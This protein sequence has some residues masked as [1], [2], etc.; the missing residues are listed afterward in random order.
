MV[1]G[2]R[3]GTMDIDPAGMVITTVIFIIIAVFILF[4]RRD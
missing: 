2:N 3:K 4:A 1:Q